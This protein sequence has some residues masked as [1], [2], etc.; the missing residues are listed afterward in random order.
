MK[1]IASFE[2]IHTCT[3]KTDKLWTAERTLYTIDAVEDAV[4]TLLAAFESARQEN[5]EISYWTQKIEKAQDSGGIF[6]KEFKPITP[7]PEVC[8]GNDPMLWNSRGILKIIRP[9]EYIRKVAGLEA[10]G[11]RP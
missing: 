4:N 2:I 7:T 1:V 6:Y 10:I 9:I 11:S 8:N 5:P 3:S